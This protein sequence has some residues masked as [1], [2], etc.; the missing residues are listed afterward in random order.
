MSISVWNVDEKEELNKVII[1][2]STFRNNYGI[3][4]GVIRT[5][6]IVILEIENTTFY[7][8]TSVDDGLFY[9]AGDVT[10]GGKK[11]VTTIKCEN[12]H[13]ENPAQ[14]TTENYVIF[15][16]IWKHIFM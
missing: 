16:I 1:S 8:N 13:F 10:V 2:N 11:Y 15:L 3:K 14:T 7:N 6:G 12:C 4:S 5:A 9:N